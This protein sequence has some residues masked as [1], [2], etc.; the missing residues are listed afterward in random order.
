MKFVLKAIYIILGLLVIANFITILLYPGGMYVTGTTN[1]AYENWL[2]GFKNKH[3]IFY[4]PLL[5]ADFMLAYSDGWTW[6]KKALLVIMFLSGWLAGSTTTLI[7]MVLAVC[8][9]LLFSKAWK[10]FN[11]RT[12]LIIGIIVFILIVIFREQE[13][14]FGWLLDIVGK[15][16]TFSNR[17]L[18]WDI[19]I[20]YILKNPVIGNG[21]LS[22]DNRHMIYLSQSVMSAHN[23]I[24]EYA[25]VG[26]Y[27][28][29]A[30][31]AILMI[32]LS[33]KLTIVARY[34]VMQALSMIFFM[35]LIVLLTEV[36]E[37]ILFYALYF[38]LWNIA[39]DFRINTDT[40][41][42]VCAINR[43]NA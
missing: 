16:A 7:C 37:D 14:M 27:I 24:L 34:P 42:E 6:D 43:S 26:G 4:M 13:H 22:I 21:Y 3:I 38:M 33:Y 9:L 35:M 39:S 15:D 29:V 8:G 11:A 10:V 32:Q 28:L 36:Y 41:G 1:L 19:A 25:F 5:I 20:D 40:E 31:Y 17:T 2:L 18:E 12:Y 30:L 23:Q